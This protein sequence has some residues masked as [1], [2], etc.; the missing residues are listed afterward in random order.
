LNYARSLKASVVK[1]D[2]GSI[3]YLVIINLQF[4]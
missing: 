3:N 2:T 1:N 4:Q